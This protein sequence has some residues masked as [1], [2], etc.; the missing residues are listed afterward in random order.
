[1]LERSVEAKFCRYATRLGGRAIKLRNT[2]RRHDVDRIL[3][4]PHGVVVWVE[5]KRPGNKPRPGQK[6]HHAWLRRLGHKVLVCDGTNL[7]QAFTYLQNLLIIAAR[8]A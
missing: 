4:L 5:L 7:P 6:R 8:Q 3:V 1:M 2:G